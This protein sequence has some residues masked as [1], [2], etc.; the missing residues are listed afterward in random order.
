M[1]N[2]DQN[3]Q[4]KLD[5]IFMPFI[6]KR[7]EDMKKLKSKFV[8][9]TSAE[10]AIKIIQSKKLWMRNAKCMNDYMEVS[11]GHDLLVKFFGDNNLRQLFFNVLEPC[12]KEIAQKAI[13]LFDHWWNNI[14]LNTFISSISEHD[15]KEEFHGRLS[16][17]RAYGQQSAKAAIVFNAPL[18]SDTKNVLKLLL[19]PTAYFNQDDLNRELKGV[20]NNIKVDIDFLVSLNNQEII[21]RI[22]AMLVMTTVSLK[23]EGFREEREWRII[24]LP[25]LVQSKL[26]FRTIEIIGGVPQIIYQIPLENNQPEMVADVNMTHLFDKVI[27]G[28]TEYP[29]PLYNAFRVALEEAGIENPESRIIISGIPLRT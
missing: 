9:Y 4:F 18:E 10:N 13:N 22:F 2:S 24:Y 15:D 27:I 5:N 25:E 21:N 8:H 16:M 3:I 1:D 28:P 17:W 11:H 20:I 7:R 19:T 29:L 26:V 12:G 14:H 23:H 6:T